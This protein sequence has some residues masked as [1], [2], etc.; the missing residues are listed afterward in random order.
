[1]IWRLIIITILCFSDMSD[2]AQQAM[3]IMF[4]FTILDIDLGLKHLGFIMKSN[5]DIKPDWHSL[6][7]K[8]EMKINFWCNKW[9]SRGGSLTLVQYVLE[10]ISVYCHSLVHIPKGVMER[11]RKT[12]YD[13][14]WKCSCRQGTKHLVKCKNYAQQKNKKVGLLTYPLFQISIGN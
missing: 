2:E 5:C 6:I 10:A 13:F 9:L 11:I 7:G 4:P 14:L 8:N 1:M 3:R 12:Y